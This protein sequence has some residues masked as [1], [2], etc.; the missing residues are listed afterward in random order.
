MI[1]AITW[2][3]SFLVHGLLVVYSLSGDMVSE[4]SAALEAGSGNDVYKIE[5]GIGIEGFMQEGTAVET[6]EAN[7]VPVQMSEARP[8][9]DE[10]K[11]VE[12]VPEDTV[13]QSANGAEMEDFPPK[14]ELEEVKPQVAPQMATLETIEQ[15]AVEEQKSAGQKQ[16]GGDPGVRRAYLGRL[17]RKLQQAKVNP[18]SRASG[19]VIVRFTVGPS[20]ELLSKEVAA[21]SG[22]QILD[23]AA[24]SAI[25]KAAPFP[26]FPEGMTADKI[27]EVVPYRFT[28]R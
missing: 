14:E 28:V 15:Q 23:A 6:V 4:A 25:D 8:Q 19:T 20:G 10:V 27:V 24:L 5:Q 9:I 17:A 7:E 22:S 21:S 18:H 16:D 12:K 13:V 26:P 11:P 1:R 3:V 2:L